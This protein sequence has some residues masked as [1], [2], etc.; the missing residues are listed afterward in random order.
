[1][2]DL[3][4]KCSE[5]GGYFSSFRMTRDRYFAMPKLESTPGPHMRFQ[6]KEMLQWAINDY[7]GLASRPELKEVAAETAAKWGV[8]GPMGARI[9]TGNTERHEELERRLAK[10]SEKEDAVLFNYGYM[11]VQ[12]TVASMVGKDDIIVID[13]LS[14]ASMMDAAF[15][16]R[17]FIPF[18]HN[19][20]V[21]LER[22]LKRATR[23]R[24]EGGVLVMIEG[25]YGMTGDLADLPVIVELKNKY[26]ARLFMDDAHGHGTMGKGHGTGVHFGLQDEVDIYFGTFAKAF[27]AIGGFSASTPDV[28]EYIRYNA[29]SQIFAKSL[30]MVVV[31]VI[32]KML[33]IL[34]AEPEIYERLWENAKKLQNG[35][36]EAGFHLGK[37]QSTITPVMI[38]A[39]DFETGVKF[40]R[41]MRDEKHIFISAVMYPVVPK[42]VLLCRMIPT[43]AHTDE[44]IA[45]TIQ[46]FKEVRDELGV[47]WAE[48]IKEKGLHHA[49]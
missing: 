1:M 20:P 43:A 40:I 42:G 16:T 6:G 7:L 3:F 30:P 13:K 45:Q 49:I 11:G 2:K 14:H 19:D 33:D 32:H 21:S 29:R 12:G 10:Y 5:P 15:S 35:L 24:D 41:K 8:S 34:E 46:A 37:T 17:Q 44:D 31:E 18:R 26:G 48:T 4:A 23:H 47:T 38:P 9:L 28:C 22:A 39:E 27:A 25:V 36:L